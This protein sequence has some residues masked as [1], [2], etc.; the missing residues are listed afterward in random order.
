MSP[1]SYLLLVCGYVSLWFIHYSLNVW[2]PVYLVIALILCRHN[3][4]LCQY[5]ILIYCIISI[6]AM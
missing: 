2:L 6:N 5:D 4:N 3:G 1:R